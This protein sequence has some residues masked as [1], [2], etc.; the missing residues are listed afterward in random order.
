MLTDYEYTFLRSY[1]LGMGDLS[2]QKM[3]SRD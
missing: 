3:L 1:I 2:I